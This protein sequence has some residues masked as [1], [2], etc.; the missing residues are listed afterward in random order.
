[1][2]HVG[3]AAEEGRPARATPLFAAPGPGRSVASWGRQG[4][5]TAVPYGTYGIAAGTGYRTR[6]WKSRLA[7]PATETD[8]LFC[9]LE[10]A[11]AEGVRVLPERHLA[12]LAHFIRV[13]KRKLMKI[14]YGPRLIGCR[15]LSTALGADRNV[16][17]SSD[18]TSSA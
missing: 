10:L 5:G 13:V 18:S 7:V 17:R 4:P 11:P 8:L 1:M 14:N 2:D 16:T 3:H 9:A 6:A 15:L 12:D